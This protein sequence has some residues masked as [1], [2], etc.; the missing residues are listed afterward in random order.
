MPIFQDSESAFP[1][2]PVND[3]ILTV[4]GFLADISTG[5]KTRGCDRY[6]IT[7]LIEGTTSR[8]KEQFFNHESCFWKID[9]WLKSAGYRSLEKGLDFEF[10]EDKAAER[11]V[12]WLNPM[13]LRCWAHLSQESYM[14]AKG[15]PAR[16][17]NNIEI[18]Y[19]DREVLE[20]DPVLRLKPTG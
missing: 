11:A 4:W 10:E 19:T 1:I 6:N 8:I 17:K 5:P 2:V 14:P 18:Y 12:A 15:P 3:Y 7:F 9:T 13:G 16:L 20:A